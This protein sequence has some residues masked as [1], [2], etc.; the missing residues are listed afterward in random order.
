MTTVGRALLGSGVISHIVI[1]REK[2][3]SSVI[4]ESVPL[5]DSLDSEHIASLAA[6]F[7]NRLVDD[8][9]ATASAISLVA[10][11]ARREAFVLA[12]NDAFL[13]VT[14]LLAISAFGVLVIGP[15]APLRRRP[16]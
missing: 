3:H 5:Y 10:S 7:T 9:R 12:F 2:F 11:D 4:T 6:H 14:A 15:S 1:E 16:P 13:V 8:A